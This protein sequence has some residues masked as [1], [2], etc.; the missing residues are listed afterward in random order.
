MKN[1]RLSLFEYN[2]QKYIERDT[3]FRVTK[4]T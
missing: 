2:N 3:R 4:N 1:K